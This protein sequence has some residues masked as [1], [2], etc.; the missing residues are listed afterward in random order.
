[1][2]TRIISALLRPAAFVVFV[3]LFA[4]AAQ[5]AHAVEVER[6]VSSKGIEA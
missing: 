5:P 6:V 2:M 1:M 4:A 3:L